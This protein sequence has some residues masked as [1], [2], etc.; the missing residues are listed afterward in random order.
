MLMSRHGWHDVV[1]DLEKDLF[2]VKAGINTLSVTSEIQVVL[3]EGI[4]P[5]S[6]LHNK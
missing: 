6:N 4:T 2:N 3:T 1:S 5:S